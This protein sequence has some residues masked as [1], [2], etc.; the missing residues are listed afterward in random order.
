M[1]NFDAKKYVKKSVTERWV[2]EYVKQN[3]CPVCMLRMDSVYHTDCVY[4][5]DM[6]IVDK[7][8]ET[9]L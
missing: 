1:S 8:E 6:K 7:K 3:K 4:L 2:N 9:V 5:D